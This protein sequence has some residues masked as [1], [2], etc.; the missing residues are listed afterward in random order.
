VSRRSPRLQ[1]QI[2]VFVRGAGADASVSDRARC[3]E[4]RCRDGRDICLVRVKFLRHRDYEI[5][6]RPKNQ[7]FGL[8]HLLK[9]GGEPTAR[10]VMPE[11]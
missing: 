3:R 4:V 11:A 6:G 9:K 10:Q 7:L 5:Q 8:L 2:A 1:Q